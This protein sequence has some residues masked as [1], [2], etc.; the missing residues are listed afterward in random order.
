MNLF[1]FLSQL[2]IFYFHHQT[3][4]IAVQLFSLFYAIPTLY[5]YLKCLIVRMINT[6]TVPKGC[7]MTP[8]KIAMATKINVYNQG[9]HY[10][11]FY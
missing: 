5:K 3:I 7:N 11:R 4:N 10:Y 1:F 8:K 6:R 9:S 2:L